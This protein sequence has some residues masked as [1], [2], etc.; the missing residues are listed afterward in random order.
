MRA[1]FVRHGDK[2]KGD[3]FNPALRHQDEPLTEEGF[4]KATVLQAYFSGRKLGAVYA[5]EYLRAFQT[6]QVISARNGLEIVRDARLNEI[7]NGV[8][9]PMTDIEI[10][11]R[12]PE[13]WAAFSA[14][15]EDVRFPGGETGAE[16][17]DRQASFLNDLVKDGRD[18]LAVC[19]EG[20]IRLLASQL[21]G[22]PVYRRHLFKVD[23]CGFLEIEYDENDG[24][25]R[26]IRMNQTVC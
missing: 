23:F 17:R 26:M 25:W 14:R 15:T 3:Y 18:A 8:I 5:S 19:H 7:D 22:M 24:F 12:F 9:E 16:V 1:Y 13:F 4:R 20:Y 2:A 6:A 10:K 21:L 11:A